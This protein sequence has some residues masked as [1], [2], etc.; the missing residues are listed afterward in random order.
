MFR[1]GLEFVLEGFADALLFHTVL[2]CLI[3][4]KVA[5]SRMFMALLGDPAFIPVAKARGLSQFLLDRHLR[6]C[7]N[8]AALD[9]IRRAS[10][11]ARE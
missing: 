2:F 6:L 8:T 1:C 4:A 11:Q 9:D 10:R 7:Y 3:G 5:M